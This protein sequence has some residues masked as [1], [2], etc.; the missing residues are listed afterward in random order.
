[1]S[2]TPKPSAQ[3]LKTVRGAKVRDGALPMK[4]FKSALFPFAANDADTEAYEA[5]PISRRDLRLFAVRLLSASGAIRHP[6]RDRL[7]ATFRLSAG[8]RAFYNLG[9]FDARLRI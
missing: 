4:A 9:L 1:M 2:R 8:D 3:L 5:N 7:L 6:Q